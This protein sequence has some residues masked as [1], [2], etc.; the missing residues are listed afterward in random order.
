MMSMQYI[1]IGEIDTDDIINKFEKKIN[2]ITC[3]VRAN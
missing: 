2:K 3:L 1:K